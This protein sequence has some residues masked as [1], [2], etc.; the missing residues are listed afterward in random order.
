MAHRIE[1][2]FKEGMVDALG[3]ATQ[4][5]IKQFLDL[6]A[7]KVK[8]IDIYKI[9]DDLNQDEL[10][11]VAQNLFCDPIIQ[12]HSFSKP[13][14]DDFDLIIEVGFKPGVTDT[15]G[16]T[17]KEGIEDIL[18]K[19][20]GNVFAAKQYLI[21]GKEITKKEGE[22]IAKELL[23]NELIQTF[24]II[25][26]DEFDPVKGIPLIL[27]EVKI[28][29]SDEVRDINLNI[30]DKELLTMSQDMMLALGVH[31][32][33]AI[34]THFDSLGRNPTDVEIEVLAQTWSEHCKH[35][36]FA[37]TITYVDKD[38]NTTEE[39]NS[40]YKTYI[41]KATF[42]IRKEKDWL[43]S[44][45]TDNAGII[46]FDEEWNLVFKVETHNSPSALDPYGGALTGLCKDFYL[47]ISR[48]PS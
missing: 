44:V 39:I 26:K 1:I 15:V 24:T 17:A 20:I 19:K 21:K 33:K 12:N 40:L 22:R 7:E 47:N 30:D 18:K 38:K 9:Q 27:P 36:I 43:V 3:N 37:S 4:Q 23:A 41:Q 42:E 13:L 35:K 34:K 2:G 45:F 14:A 29:P 5:K 8:T 32:M 28:E 16:N 31:E 25:T 48:I 46:K 10:Q 11:N 6:T